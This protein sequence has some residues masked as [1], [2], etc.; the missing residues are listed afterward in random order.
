MTKVNSI[1]EKGEMGE[2][3]K[4]VRQEIEK[5][6]AIFAKLDKFEEEGVAKIPHYFDLINNNLFGINGMILAGC[7]A[8]IALQKFNIPN[9]LIIVPLV[10]CC[11]IFIANCCMME[12]SRSQANYQSLSRKDRDKLGMKQRISTWCSLFVVI[13]TFIV[14]ATFC[15]LMIK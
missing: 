4:L 12:Y 8:I 11:F 6:N 2:N 5:A 13:T 7:M 1:T 9:W 15:W 10:N 14:V 3:E